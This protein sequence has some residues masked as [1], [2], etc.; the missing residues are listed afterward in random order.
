MTR[1]LSRS[2]L[3]LPEFDSRLGMYRLAATAAGVSLVALIQPAEGKIIYTKSNRSILP[4]GTLRIDLNHDGIADFVLKDPR[5]TSTAGGSFNQ[6]S[7]APAHARNGVWGHTNTFTAYAS[8]L[9]AN[10]RIGP[11]GQFLK[12][13]GL[14]AASSV[15]GGVHRDGNFSCTG[16]WAN[17]QNRYLGLKFQIKGK[18]HFGWARLSVACSAGNVSIDGT[19]TGYAYESVANKSILT[20]KEHGAD[21][22]DASGSAATLGHLAQGAVARQRR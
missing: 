2:R 9:S 11:K 20:G 3:C 4:N 5:S 8:A 7:A 16:P 21:D 1:P 6:L 10:V 17:V 13:S 19:L 15:S 18:T 14:M 12:K 22:A